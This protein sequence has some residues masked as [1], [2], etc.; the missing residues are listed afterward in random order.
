M[1]A[2]ANAADRAAGTGNAGAETRETPA[3]RLALALTAL[4]LVL[5]G[6]FLY[7]K[8]IRNVV[9]LGLPVTILF[10]VGFYFVMKYLLEKPAAVHRQKKAGQGNGTE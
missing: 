5:A 7:S 3:I 2:E 9:P 6:I 8:N 1:G 10:G 4:I